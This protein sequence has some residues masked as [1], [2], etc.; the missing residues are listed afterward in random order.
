MMCRDSFFVRG[1]GSTQ[2]YGYKCT[3]KWYINHNI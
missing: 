2:I 3:L 1:Y